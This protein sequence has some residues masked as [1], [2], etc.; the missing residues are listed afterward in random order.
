MKQAL[1]PL[2]YCFWNNKRKNNTF[3]ITYQKYGIGNLLGEANIDIDFDDDA[4]SDG[5][6]I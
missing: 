5:Q 4:I 6:T 3:P 1:R 2:I